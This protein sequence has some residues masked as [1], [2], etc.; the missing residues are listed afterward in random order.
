[1][2]FILVIC[3]VLCD[4][5]ITAF[6]SSAE[7]NADDKKYVDCTIQCMVETTDKVIPDLQVKL[8]NSAG[9][10][11]KLES[12]SYQLET[13]EKYE[14]CITGGKIIDI[15]GSFTIEQEAAGSYE[16]IIYIP[17]ENLK[18]SFKD[19]SCS[20][21]K[22]ISMADDWDFDWEWSSS[23]A[24]VATVSD[25]GEV[26]GVGTGSTVITREY[27]TIK[28]TATVT[29]DY[30]KTKCKLNFYYKQPSAVIDVDAVIKGE[31]NISVSVQEDGTYEL[32][33]G[34]EYTYKICTKGL[35]TTDGKDEGTFEVPDD[36]E[37]VIDI[38]IDF[39]EPVFKIEET[40]LAD[41]QGLK[42]NE[43]VKLLC[44]NFNELYKSDDVY[45]KYAFN[46]KNYEKLSS[47]ELEL[48]YEK[49]FG[50]KCKCG[51]KEADY[52]K[53][54]FDSYTFKTI[55]IPSGQTDETQGIE[56]TKNV[57]YFIGDE[58]KDGSDLE[59]G[60]E[61]T[62]T[63]DAEG[64]EKKE[65]KVTTSLFEQEITLQPGS[66][67]NPVVEIGENNILSG[68]SGAIIEI[69]GVTISDYSDKLDWQ[70]ICV[71]EDD[72][73]GS[74]KK[75]K[76]QM[77]GNKITIYLEEAEA[78]TYQLKYQYGDAASDPIT[79][80]VKKI[81]IDVDWSVV[82]AQSKNY[83]A[84]NEFK[85]ALLVSG[86]A[87]LFKDVEKNPSLIGKDDKILITGCVEAKDVG[88]YES[89]T[90]TDIKAPDRYDVSGINKQEKKIANGLQI[91]QITQKVTFQQLYLQYRIN[92]AAENSQVLFSEK[93]DNLEELKKELFQKM[94]VGE[95]VDYD[96]GSC[97]FKGVQYDEDKNL[98]YIGT[99]KDN[100]RFEFPGFLF[101]FEI[102]PEYIKLNANEIH[103]IFEIVQ[104]D[105]ILSSAEGSNWC[106]DKPITARFIEGA[107]YF[108]DNEYNEI[109]FY[110]AD[111][112]LKEVYDGDIETVSKISTENIDKETYYEVLFL[113]TDYPKSATVVAYIHII[114]ESK[115]GNVEEENDKKPETI[116]VNNKEYPVIRLYLDKTAPE[117]VFM[118]ER[119][120][121]KDASIYMGGI[122]ESKIN[123]KLN[124]TGFPA[125]RIEYCFVNKT[126]SVQN[127]THI[128]KD[129]F[130]GDIKQQDESGDG[131]MEGS[132][133]AEQGEEY[134][135]T[136][137]CPAEEGDYIVVIKTVNEGGIKEYY[138][139]NG[140]AVDTTPPNINVTFTE[141]ESKKDITSEILDE[142]KI[143]RRN[144]V[145]MKIDL[146]EAHIEEVKVTITAEGIEN[147]QDS[148]E[149]AN[150][151]KETTY[152]ENKKVMSS[153]YE[154][155]FT[156][157][158]NYQIE[159]TVIDKAGNTLKQNSDGQPEPVVYN[160]TV[161][162]TVPNG[163]I[164]TAL[165]FDQIISNDGKKKGVVSMVKD[166]SDKLPWL[167]FVPEVLYSVFSKDTI[168]YTMSGSDEISQVEIRYFLS[169]EQMT[170][171]KLDKL[172]EESWHSYDKTENNIIEVNESC[173]IYGR[174]KD[175]AGNISYFNTQGMITDNHKP[176]ILLSLNKETNKNGFYNGNVSFSADIEDKI[177][178][179][180]TASSGLQY[181]AYY[182]KKDGK[183]IS[184]RVVYDISKDKKKEKDTLKIEKES[185]S[186]KEFNSNDVTLC[187]TAIDN[188]GN[189]STEEIPLKIDN[190][191]PE[192]SVSYDDQAVGEYCNHTRTAT[193]SIKERNL[194]TDDVKIVAKGAHGNTG[195]VG[196]WSHSGNTGKSDN[197]VYTCKV[198]FTEDDDYEFTV[199]CV[200][201]AGNK[202][203]KNFS[204]KFTVDATKPVISVSYNG[205][206]PEQNAYY[207][208]PITATITITEHNFDASKVDI[209][210]HADN[211]SAS[212][213]SGFSSNGDVH[214]ATVSYSADGTY[215][216][217]VAY[218]D[219]A[220]NAADSYSGSTFTVDL[221]EP[222][223]EITNIQDK[224]ANKGDVKP[225]IICTDVNYD[226]D[227]AVIKLY[228]ANNG[229]I[230]LKDVAISSQAINN[231]EQ[232]TLDFPE[233][234][235]LDDVYTLTAEVTDKAGNETEK[236]I[237]FSVNRFGSVYTLG[238]ETGEWLTSGVCSYIQEGRSVVIVET[239][240]DEVVERNIAYTQG[241]VNAAVVTVNEAGNSSS[242]ERENGTYYQMKDRRGEG[243]WYQ[244]EYTISADNFLSEGRYS[245]QIDST[246]K[247]GN[248]TSNVS[249]KRTEG[250]LVVEFAVDQT[251]PS[252]VITG[253]E[254]REVY[255]EASHTVYLDVQ[256]NLATDYVTV[257]LNGE[258]YGTYKAS[259][260]EEL[261]NGLIPV[262]VG[263]SLSTQTIQLMAKDMAGNILSE[264]SEGKYGKS[265]DDF[266]IIVTTNP[267]VRFLHTTWF[268]LLLL[269]I[270]VICG[271]SVFIIIKRKKMQVE[272]QS[273]V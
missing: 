42:S 124:N 87:V 47:Q 136:I 10:E 36:D 112:E 115:K 66:V 189:K 71:K 185:I 263:Q 257:Y 207:K 206:A 197:A 166:I 211:S 137:D 86:D 218:T 219:E 167:T 119:L 15:N 266:H 32:L 50:L 127:N 83:D 90:I 58:E 74:S 44:T 251:A 162:T 151:L 203:A 239:N 175:K 17:F 65:N 22:T 20:V 19:K 77:T 143:F 269:M 273:D 113:N 18:Y 39:I 161:D 25:T 222:E 126:G 40:D 114:P 141:I 228:G 243:Q 95:N 267:L 60:K 149:C 24:D 45:W 55:Y 41:I 213:V 31:D 249:N 258:E 146:T 153:S 245:V 96:T 56:I 224:S 176:D 98:A 16:K 148:G 235:I 247:A 122:A 242:Q 178:E 159:I 23:K 105:R 26:T 57:K 111:S 261:E 174:V 103:A 133:N 147:K 187:V 144:P 106:N 234:Q 81:K 33:S 271:I 52:S 108:G 132:I 230:D 69:S 229:E 5:D 70:W 110:E 254:N 173:I 6:T 184:S 200:D 101:S 259:D 193:I 89:F 59:V 129:E 107:K 155:D 97:T 237:E 104:E 223:I 76:V 227:K 262:K 139:S 246:D 1:M 244:Y 152:D 191:K 216:L 221:I 199:S 204:D 172:P 63:V 264:K 9:D 35:H 91:S 265:F 4:A 209:Q 38:E 123:F 256:D 217:D 208:E 49:T 121:V 233:T 236:S 62:I 156:D 13:G 84:T 30:K 164:E 75:L 171:E 188:A 186:A 177:P 260:I 54:T 182:L 140:F 160:V 34:K 80:T 43:T 181:V 220:G 125:S 67:K 134:I 99:D 194:N 169:A 88:R 3:L 100:V 130:I 225:V 190:V 7:N 250:N 8:K 128:G 135:Y 158:A 2:A 27:K 192:I 157:D 180:G 94:N 142:N 168:Q 241:G 240:V 210:M 179:G 255:N 12:D 68:Y 252:A 93:V 102:V 14:Y 270:L 195:K 215:G 28:Q 150:A 53:N 154:I 248:H 253:A 131:I 82:P 226:S 117:V 214:T 202:A 79:I 64:F 205:T 92:K 238:T 11:V 78:G 72:S 61:Y 196:K 201:K 73:D 165:L 37:A 120:T 138:C 46:S 85:I 116:S 48:E 118:D 231:G 170:E 29:V 268:W 145:K 163:K 109:C 232:F 21:G 272:N 212:G 198:T 183:H 51:D